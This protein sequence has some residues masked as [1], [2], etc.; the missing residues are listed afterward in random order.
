M[1]ECGSFEA[2]ALD[3]HVSPSAVSQRI[4]T[5]ERDVGQRVVV[6]GS[7]CRLTAA[8]EVLMRAARAIRVVEDEAQWELRS[9]STRA[10]LLDVAVNADS[11][12]TWFPAVFSAPSDVL[13]SVGLRVHL[14]DES[15]TAEL[16]RDGTVVAAVSDSSIP[17][18]GFTASALGVMRYLPVVATGLLVPGDGREWSDLPVVR[19]GPDDEL[20]RHLLGPVDGSGSRVV[21]DVPSPEGCLA[22][23][24]AG[25]GWGAVPQLQLDA[26]R[27][28]FAVLA[29][30][31]WLDVPLYWHV[32]R[33]D[34]AR[35]AALT[36]AVQEAAEALRAPAKR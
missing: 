35:L 17:A 19:F 10:P 9:G 34:S 22:A 14:I 7:P 15:R 33:V 18:P 1:V 27:A 5:I 20:H 16:L 13:E 4:R 32:P 25:L 3:L 36:M 2:A 23:I 29:D 31:V 6:R 28:G 12:A 26:D 21:H 24:R 30:D 11:L 8:G